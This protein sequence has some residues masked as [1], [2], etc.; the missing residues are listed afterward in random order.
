VQRAL[1]HPNAT[2]GHVF[3][4]HPMVPFS[5][6]MSLG[7]GCVMMRTLFCALLDS[8]V[9]SAESKV[10][11]DITSFRTKCALQDET[12]VSIHF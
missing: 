6:G 2:D 10:Q 4:S 11:Q 1:L 5:L 3:S 9:C 7:L 8:K 12:M